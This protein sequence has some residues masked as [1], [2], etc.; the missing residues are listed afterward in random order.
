MLGL[1]LNHVSKRGPRSWKEN[2]KQRPKWCEN[3][4]L[5]ILCIILFKIICIV[6]IIVVIPH[7]YDSFSNTRNSRGL[8][9]LIENDFRVFSILSGIRVCWQR[10]GKTGQQI[11]IIFLGQVKYDT[12]KY[13][14]HFEDFALNPL[15]PGWIYSFVGSVLAGNITEKRV[16][17]FSWNF[18]DI[19]EI[20]QQ[21]NYIDCS[22]PN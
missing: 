14:Q 20:T 10:Y 8:F 11:F 19:F 9:D 16:H 5:E 15:D 17:R 2:D 13:L 7:V 3:S 6:I 4:I 22:T 1:K 21:N 12:G 18:H